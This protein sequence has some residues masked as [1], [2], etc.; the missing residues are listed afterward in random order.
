[1]MLS[2]QQIQLKAVDGQGTKPQHMDH[3]VGKITWEDV[4][5]DQD[6]FSCPD[7]SSFIFCK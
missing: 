5:L 1:M 7:E 6:V 4:S 2:F 3:A